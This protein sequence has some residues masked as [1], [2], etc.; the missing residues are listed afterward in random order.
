MIATTLRRYL[1]IPW[2]LHGDDHDGADCWG[3]V[4]LIYR[5]VLGVALPGYQDHYAAPDDDGVRRAL[6]AGR[7]AWFEVDRPQPLDVVLFHG[8]GMPLHA[9]VCADAG[10]FLHVRRG[11]TS[12]VERL[13]GVWLHRMEGVYR[14]RMAP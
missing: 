4:R 2:R 10:R 3:L 12:H 9:G 11:G 5:E 8:L 1:G 7:D 14:C 6:D 13:A